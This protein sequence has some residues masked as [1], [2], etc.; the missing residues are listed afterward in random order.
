MFPQV[1]GVEHEQ[2]IAHDGAGCEETAVEDEVEADDV[3]RDRQNKKHGERHALGPHADQR[4]G[5]HD[6]HHKGDVLGI[7]QYTNVLVC[8]RRVVEVWRWR[9][10]DAGCAE[11]RRDEHEAE[12][13]F[14]NDINDFFHRLHETL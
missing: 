4:D 9:R 2:D 6:S 5:K 10:E 13:N 14:E 12:Q 1:V 11:N 7:H 3:E 8:L